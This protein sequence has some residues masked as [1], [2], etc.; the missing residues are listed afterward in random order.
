M[1]QGIS[2]DVQSAVDWPVGPPQTPLCCTLGFSTAALAV[3]L[4]DSLCSCAWCFYHFIASNDSLTLTRKR[5][6]NRC[7]YIYIHTTYIHV[8]KY[9]CIYIYI[10]YTYAHTLPHLSYLMTMSIIYIYIYN[11]LLSCIIYAV[12]GMYRIVSICNCICVLSAML[13]PYCH[14]FRC[15]R[16]METYFEN[17][18]DLLLSW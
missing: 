6:S 1:C 7:I 16:I 5:L 11:V 3:G 17:H 18:P 8:Y 14:T 10:Y 4:R 13:F 2:K 12:H 15:A 9:A